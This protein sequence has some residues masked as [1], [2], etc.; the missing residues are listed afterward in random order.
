MG[1]KHLRRYLQTMPHATG[2]LRDTFGLTD[3][4]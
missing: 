3:A 1:E 2:D 4:S